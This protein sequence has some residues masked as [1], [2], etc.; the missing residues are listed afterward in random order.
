MLLE[1]EGGF[2]G[3]LDTTALKP[4]DRWIPPRQR[5]KVRAIVGIEV[6][7]AEGEVYPGMESPHLRFCQWTMAASKGHPLMARA[8]RDTVEALLRVFAV[9]NG[10]TG[11]EMRISGEEEEM[12]RGGGAAVWTGAGL[13]TLSEETGTEM[14][15][16]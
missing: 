14:G 7:A 12:V 4:I 15:W 16:R 10:T 9:E 5:R 6:E 13:E 3:A 11:A 2:Y 1:S 8:I